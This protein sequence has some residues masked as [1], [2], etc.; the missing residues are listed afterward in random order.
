VGKKHGPAE[1]Q[2]QPHGIVAMFI[3]S[4]STNTRSIIVFC[5]FIDV[6]IFYVLSYFVQ[7]QECQIYS[8]VFCQILRDYHS[9]ISRGT[10]VSSDFLDNFLHCFTC[11]VSLL[12]RKI[13]VPS[14]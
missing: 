5:Y 4:V 3:S 11:F 2:V 1:Y 14:H 9:G 12:D 13:R 10:M 7:L 6:M 8:C